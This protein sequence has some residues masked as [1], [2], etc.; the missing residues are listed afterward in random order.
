MSRLATQQDVLRELFALSGNQCAF[1][2]CM[3]ALISDKGTFI[4]QL[5]HIEAANKGGQRYNSE[6]TDEERRSK[7]NLL[8]LCYAHHRETDDEHEYTVERLKKIK[9]DHEDQFKNQYHLP[10]IFVDKVLGSIETFLNQISKISET[11]N[12]TNILVHGLE[13]Q[14][15]ELLRRTPSQNSIDD[16]KYF[17]SQIDFIKDLKKRGNSKTAIEKLIEFKV[18]NWHKITEKLK[19]KVLANL[20]MFY[21]D[22]HD[23]LNAGK[24]FMELNDVDYETAESLGIICLGYA[25]SGK[26]QEFDICFQ[27]ALK[28]GAEDI[29]LWVGYVQR[30]KKIKSADQI[31]KELPT[32]VSETSPILFS[33]GGIFIEEG[34]KRE[35]ITLLKRTLEKNDDS[36]EKKS[37]ITGLIATRIIQDIVDPIKFAFDNYS[38]EELQELHEAKT[39]LTEAWGSIVDTEMAAYKWHL[40]LNRGVIN[41]L[42]KLDNQALLD[43]QKAFDLSKEG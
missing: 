23:G 30:Y 14:M 32:T 22:I 28:K 6:Q 10:E 9:N 41:K 13:E 18:K 15:S 19:Y 2:N 29:N 8:L 27:R 26:N 31:L 34:R 38:E 37:D 42:L 21:I 11:T 7:A 24:Y 1:P 4:A 17:D 33:L 25:I 5:C 12:E 39:L 20:G 3:H 43:F 16:D 35:G 36:L 40:I